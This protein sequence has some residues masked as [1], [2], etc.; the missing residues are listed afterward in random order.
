MNSIGA[1]ADMH[2]SPKPQEQHP[3]A[4]L[5]EDE[6]VRVDDHEGG[7]RYRADVALG[8]KAQVGQVVLVFPMERTLELTHS[9]AA[10]QR[11]GVAYTWGPVLP[12]DSGQ[13]WNRPQDEQNMAL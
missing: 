9:T 8:S 4:K 1:Y 5:Q 7:P 11:H 2:E 12:N 6:G 10:L 3:P 13:V